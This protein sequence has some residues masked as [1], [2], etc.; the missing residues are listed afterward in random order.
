MHLFC[1][2]HVHIWLIIIVH[3][4]SWLRQYVIP[5]YIHNVR[6]TDGQVPN[7]GFVDIV[8]SHS[9]LFHQKPR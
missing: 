5:G 8:D 9:W 4:I 7:R 2:S 3:E 6:W 1:Y